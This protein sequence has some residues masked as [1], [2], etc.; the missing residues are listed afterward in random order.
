MTDDTKALVAAQLTYAWMV[1]AG[2]IH[3]PVAF[4]TAPGQSGPQMAQAMGAGRGLAN[5]VWALYEDF[6]ARLNSS[7]AI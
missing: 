1:R 5:E 4:L 3:G 2:A 7:D 6:M